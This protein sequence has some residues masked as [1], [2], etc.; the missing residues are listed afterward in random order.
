MPRSVSYYYG[1]SI[2]LV[3]VLILAVTLPWS[4]RPTLTPADTLFA[5][6]CGGGLLGTLLAGLSIDLRH[7]RDPK[8]GRPNQKSRGIPHLIGL[9]LMAAL[10]LATTNF[11]LEMFSIVAGALCIIMAATPIADGMMDTFFLDHDE[12]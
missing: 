9:M 4:G 11:F 12:F 2:A 3:F 6:V 5:I 10:F 8:D 7:F 1:V